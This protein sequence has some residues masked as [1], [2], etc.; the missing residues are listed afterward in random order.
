MKRARTGRRTYQM[1]FWRIV[2]IR[3]RSHATRYD[4]VHAG[5]RYLQL[6]HKEPTSHTS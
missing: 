4:W 3:L 1:T 5:Y 6:H 2:T